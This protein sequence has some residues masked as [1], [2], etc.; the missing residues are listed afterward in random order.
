MDSPA[1]SPVHPHT[2]FRTYLH[3][4][5]PPESKR[6]GNVLIYFGAPIALSLIV[7]VRAVPNPDTNWSAQAIAIFSFFLGLLISV[8]VS[9]FSVYNRLRTTAADDLVEDREE[10]EFAMVELRRINGIIAY[11]NLI[12]VVA[13]AASIFLAV[14]NV[15]PL[16]QEAVTVCLYTH[17]LLNALLL[18]KRGHVLFQKGF[19]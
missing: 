10:I 9:A 3:S 14:S 12:S 11:L 2:I 4:L 8:Q 19:G 7:Y 16:I 17:F 15:R 5:R 13:M 6:V 1:Q 18:L